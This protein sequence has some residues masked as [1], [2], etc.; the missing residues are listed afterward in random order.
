MRK[1]ELEFQ[2]PNGEWRNP[3]GN[4]APGIQERL[5]SVDE[6]GSAYTRLLRFEPGADS[7]PNGVQQHDFWEEVFIVEGDITDTRLGQRFTA[8]MYACRPPG[9]EHGPWTSE[10]GVLMV[11][12]RYGMAP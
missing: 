5:L 3:P 1:P 7:S 10:T 6:D 9:M 4:E 8:G 2:P 11:E 12:F